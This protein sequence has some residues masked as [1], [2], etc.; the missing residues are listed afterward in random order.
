MPITLTVSLDSMYQGLGL[1]LV[2]CSYIQTLLNL[3][4]SQRSDSVR[5][6]QN[7]ELGA[8]TDIIGKQFQA[9][10]P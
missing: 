10:H 5:Y 9:F 7:V 4:S 6:S 1:K 2:R 8:L 3:L